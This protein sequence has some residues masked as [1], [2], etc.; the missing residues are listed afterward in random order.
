MRRKFLE[1]MWK[2]LVEPQLG[3]SFSRNHCLA[4]SIEAVQEMNLATKFPKTYWA[5]A[6]LTVNAKQG[7]GD[8]ENSE[9]VSSGG[10][11]DYAKISKAISKMQLQGISVELPD[12]NESQV[13]FKPKT[14]SILFGLGGLKGVSVD[15]FKTIINNRPYLSYKDFYDKMSNIKDEA[16]GELKTV[17]P[18]AQ[19]IALIK[20]GAFRNIEKNKTRKEL[21]EEYLGYEMDKVKS[22][23]K[24]KITMANLGKLVDSNKIPKEYDYLGRLYYYKEWLDESALNSDKTTYN[25]SEDSPVRF[26]KENCIPFLKEDSYTTISGVY[27]V[28]VKDFKKFYDSRMA[29]LKEWMATDEA[30]SA[31]N[32]TAR[33]GYVDELFG[34]YCQGTEAHWEM[35]SVGYYY[36]HH[37]LYNVKLGQYCGANIE[38]VVNFTDMPAQMEKGKDFYLMGVITDVNKTKRM[39]SLLTLNSGVIDVKFNDMLFIQYSKKIISIDSSG[40]KTTLEEPWLQKGNAIIVN[41]ARREGTFLCKRAY[42]RDRFTIAL[43]DSLKEEGSCQLKFKRV[44][45]KVDKGF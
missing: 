28:K 38:P 3:Y 10:T 40:K 43:I 5:C 9:E 33:K 35:D 11:S 17:L 36:K 4:Y 2:I 13:D 14:N 39:V 1:Y 18:T 23:N 45:E 29:P 41:G 16:T 22:Y 12:I 8:D 21:I 32:A 31:Y 30:V 6:C 25:F 26:F 7:V 37:E 42:G 20:S 34:K 27:S 24:E 19:M 15:S 44:E